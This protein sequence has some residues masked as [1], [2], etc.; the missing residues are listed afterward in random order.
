MKGKYAQR[1]EGE[2]KRDIKGNERAMKS[3]E[4]EMKR[5]EGA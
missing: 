2:M 1:K 3:N 4:G 5:N